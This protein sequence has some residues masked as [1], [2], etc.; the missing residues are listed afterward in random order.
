MGTK[1]EMIMLSGH[2]CASL[3]VGHARKSMSV[4]NYRI[5]VSGS[6]D[7][8][9]SNETHKTRFDRRPLIIKELTCAMFTLNKKY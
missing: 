5:T 7:L 4:L 8:I 6:P 3:H 9:K 1:S 2:L